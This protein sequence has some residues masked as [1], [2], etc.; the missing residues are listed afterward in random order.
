MNMESFVAYKGKEFSPLAI[1][2]AFFKRFPDMFLG[3]QTMDDLAFV[4]AFFHQQRAQNHFG[5]ACKKDILIASAFEQ[6]QI[7]RVA[8]KFRSR[9]FISDP[10]EYLL[11]IQKIYG[12]YDTEMFKELSAHANFCAVIWDQRK[13]Q[14]LAGV[15]TPLKYFT[16][17]HYGYTPQNHE[18]IFSNDIK[19]LSLLV[20]DVITMEANTYMRDGVVYPING[21]NYSDENG[22]QLSRKRELN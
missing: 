16:H 18:C 15:T 19:L 22:F 8:R 14:M 7:A 20:K 3:I 11:L 17:L 12:D 1:V 9:Y 6:E 10:A 5:L 4:Q 21:A 13:K 2:D